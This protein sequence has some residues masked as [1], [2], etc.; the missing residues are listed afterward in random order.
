MEGCERP[1]W[2][3]G[4]CNIH[5]R[6]LERG[7]NTDG[8]GRGSPGKTRGIRNLEGSYLLKSGYVKV[9]VDG[10]WKLEHRH[11]MEQELGR[12]LVA[13]EN[14]HHKDGNKS[15]NDPSNLELWV[16]FQPSGQRPEE[17]LEWAEEII[18]RYK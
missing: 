18:R 6:R 11:V 12:P 17:L 14:V 1:I 7:G 4:H 8:V 10:V 16:T 9:R 15:N 3:K 5:Y 13:G 2:A